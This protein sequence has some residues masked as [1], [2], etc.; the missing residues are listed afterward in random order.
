MNHGI[1]SETNH[2]DIY[3]DAALTPITRLYIAFGNAAYEGVYGV[4]AAVND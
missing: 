1:L 2:L 4:D 3:I